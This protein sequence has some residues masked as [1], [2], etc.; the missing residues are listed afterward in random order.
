MTETH[1][2]IES[3]TTNKTAK[4]VSELV[5][6]KVG[7]AIVYFRV[8]KVSP[9]VVTSEETRAVAAIDENPFEAAS[10]VIR[11][12]VRVIGSHL[13][14]LREEL[15]P[16]ELTVELGFTFEAKGKAT[17]VPVFLTGET[18]GGLA[19]KV[20]AKWQRENSSARDS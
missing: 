19:F 6:T 7:N 20:T 14:E 4:D 8:D 2:G 12:S 3:D 5:E 9:A 10:K 15:M 13:H 17:I 11:E 16:E 1:S 18:S